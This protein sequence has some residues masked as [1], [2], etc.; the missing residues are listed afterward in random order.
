MCHDLML[1]NEVPA[2][3]AWR[4]LE[5]ARLAG[6]K[7]VSDL[8]RRPGMKNKIYDN[9]INK[10]AKRD[11]TRRFLKGNDWPPMCW[12]HTPCVNKITDR[13]END[14]VPLWRPHEVVGVLWEN[15]SQVLLEQHGLDLQSQGHLNMVAAQLG[16]PPASLHL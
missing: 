14:W 9:A 1:S 8:V 3:R 11:L 2:N 4:L 10:N 16:A 7:N 12:V 6:T 15:A 13:V 5:N